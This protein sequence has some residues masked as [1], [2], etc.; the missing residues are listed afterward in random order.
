M[1][2]SGA[3]E[4]EPSAGRDRPCAAAVSGV[5]LAFR[6]TFGDAERGCPC[7]FAGISVD[8]HQASPRRFLAGPVAHH[9]AA[10]V[11]TGGAEA[12]IRTRADDAGAII[13]LRRAFRPAAV[14]LA[15]LFLL[16][17]PHQRHIVSL[18]ENV[19]GFRVDGCAAPIRAAGSS[20]EL[21]GALRRSAVLVIEPRSG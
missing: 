5:L 15:G 7:D 2:R 21:N 14:V 16:D 13:F 6:K 8:G 17:P 20:Q 19:S 18:Y 11:L 9:F 4:D 12:R 3:D 1:V 10:G